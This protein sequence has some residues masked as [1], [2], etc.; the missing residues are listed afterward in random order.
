MDGGFSF[1]VIG[2][3]FKI[4]GPKKSWAFVGFS[5]IFVVVV[6]L[7]SWGFI[8]SPVGIPP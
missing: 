7:L 2:W 6:V 4:N 3:A 5:L 1:S 8:L